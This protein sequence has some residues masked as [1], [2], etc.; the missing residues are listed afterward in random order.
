V[1]TWKSLTVAAASL[2]VLGGA[3]A[4]FS[5]VRFAQDSYRISV[6]ASQDVTWSLSVPKANRLVSL[7]LDGGVQSIGTVETP[8]GSMYNLTGMGTG[9]VAGVAT[10]LVAGLDPWAWTPGAD[11]DLSGRQSGGGFWVWRSSNMASANITAI[12]VA[13]LHIDYLGGGIAC[14]QAFGGEL[15]EGWTL[16]PPLIGDCLIGMSSIPWLYLVAPTLLV[17]GLVLLWRGLRRRRD[18][19]T[20]TVPE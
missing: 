2:L 3:V 16:T 5:V 20:A 4:F 12:G 10:R 18:G 11:I 13:S 9:S 6:D 8:L 15:Q 17:P 19:L 1:W 7:R 14:G